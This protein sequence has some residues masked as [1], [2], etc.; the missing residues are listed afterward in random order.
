MNKMTFKR[1]YIFSNVEKKAK[2]IQFS[3][4]MNVITSSQIDG[5]DRGKSVIMRSLYH[6]LGADSQFDDK[7]DDSN[8]VY[9]LS[10]SIKDTD[11][12]IYRNNRL[13]KFFDSDKNLLFSTVDRSDLAEQLNRYFNFAVQLPNRKEDK[14]EITPPVYNYLLYYIDQDHY[15]GT[16]FSSF[17]GLGQYT[18][19]K[20]N[21]LYYH[22]GVFDE[23]YFN[24]IKQMERLDKEK[25]QLIKKQNLV[26]GMFEKISSD[27]KN[28]TFSHDLSTLNL[29][30]NK[31]KEE[32]SKIVNSLNK[33]K[34][35]IIT[36]KNQRIEFEIALS[37]L[38]NANKETEKEIKALNEHI[39]PLC[40]TNLTD[41]TELRV[42]KYNSS[43]DII[44]VSNDVQMSILDLNRK[45]N[46]ETENY[47][48]ILAM[49]KDY[50]ER[51]NIGNE[52]I[53]DVL[54]HRGFIEVRDS[55]LK[56][57]GELKE[58]LETINETYNDCIKKKRKYSET[59]KTINDKYY[60]LLINDKTLF[61]LSEIDDKRFENIKKTFTASGSNKPIA[62]VMWYTN[63]IKLKNQ[64]NPEAIKFPIVFDSPNNAETD[65]IKRHELLEYLLDNYTEDNQLIIST[66]G[67]E[68]ESFKKGDECTVIELENAKYNLLDETDYDE[69][70]SLVF[71]LSK[72]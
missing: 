9:I 58:S 46:A 72:K 30:V 38:Q 5:T 34:N 1:I 55:L 42:S 39:C 47:Q 69:H 48:E 67:F 71:E 66:I 36:L 23:T 45:I 8:K 33:I 25:A 28:T 12:F 59:K 52:Q 57:F 64:F 4:G 50:E 31:T 15:N 17:S 60:E 61:G 29:E 44:I 18:N 43:S 49:M 56:D 68:V 20:E 21:V 40:K 26:E 62:T 24:I 51:L 7:W 6:A 54:K 2:C 63:L 37:E 19:Y 16:N 70:K 13:F 65:D 22:F 14:L 27:L 11:Y 10:F 3:S 53:D 41:T 35:K 32:Y